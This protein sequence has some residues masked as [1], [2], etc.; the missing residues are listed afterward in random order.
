[1]KQLIVMM[2]MIVL[3]VA[4]FNLIAGDDDH[5]I[6]NV[7]KGVWKEEIEIRTSYP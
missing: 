1:M 4:I 7:M 6:L 5:S 2:V 3:G